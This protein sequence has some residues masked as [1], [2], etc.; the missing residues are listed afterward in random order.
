MVLGLLEEDGEV[1]VVDAD[2]HEL[3]LLG[4]AEEH[5]AVEPR[6]QTDGKPGATKLVGCLVGGV[7]AREEVAQE[8]VV[9]LDADDVLADVAVGLEGWDGADETVQGLVLLIWMGPVAG[10]AA[11]GIHENVRKARE[12]LVALQNAMDLFRSEMVTGH[13]AWR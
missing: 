4:R 8:R 10:P 2:D 13:G 9:A 5:T 6:E 12:P 11:C 7:G 1:L 3:G